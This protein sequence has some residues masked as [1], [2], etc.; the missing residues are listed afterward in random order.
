MAFGFSRLIQ[1]AGK[2]TDYFILWAVL[3]ALAGFFFPAA[4]VWAV[5]YMSWILGIIMFGMGLVLKPGDF[6]VLLRRPLPVAAGVVLQFVLMPGL[7]FVLVRIFPLPAELAVGVLLLG[8]CPGGTASN[9]IAYLAKGDVALSVCVTA[10]TNLLAPLMTPLLLLLLL[11]ETVQLAFWEMFGSIVRVV[12]LPVVLG[13][14]LARFQQKHVQKV[15]PLMPLLSVAGVVLLVAAIIGLNRAYLLDMGGLIVAVVVLHNLCG[16]AGG[17][18]GARL[19]RLPAAQCRTLGIE[20]GMQ[21]SGL[22]TVL[23]LAFFYPPAAVAGALFTVWHNIS[24]SLL[25]AFVQWRNR[26]VR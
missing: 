10:L 3:F 13:M 5:P 17:Y 21:N 16:L 23:A 19:L 7:A 14:L 25:V 26:C 11:G 8:C 4:F 20:V 22:A 1:A 9:I 24:G 18:G 12:L 6:S 15:L 2:L